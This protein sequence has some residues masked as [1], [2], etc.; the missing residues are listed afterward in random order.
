MDFLSTA[1]PLIRSL[2]YIALP[3]TLIFLIQSIMTFTGTDAGDGLEADFNGDLSEAGPFQLFSFRNL[4]NFLLGFSW[5]GIAYSSVISNPTFL[6]LASLAS[7]IAFVGIFFFA[8]G[9][10]QKLAED[11]TFRIEN[12]L[13]KSASVYLT[14]PGNQT[15][16]GK[17]MVGVKG[18]MHEI[19]AITSG[20]QIASGEEVLVV[21]IINQSLIEVEKIKS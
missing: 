3:S 13:K 15:G 17:V 2:W 21:K 20:Q 8:I 18:A 16:K 6:I 11:N 19:E 12:C 7:G 5:T 1:D 10:I 14:I 9:Q 4:I